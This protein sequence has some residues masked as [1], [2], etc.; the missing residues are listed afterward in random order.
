MDVPLHAAPVAGRFQSR[1]FRPG[2]ASPSG[3]MAYALAVVAM[4]A[5]AALSALLA[6]VERQRPEGALISEAVGRALLLVAVTLG[7]T[8]GH[9]AGFLAAALATAAVLLA[10][11][12]PIFTPDWGNYSGYNSLDLLRDGV[13]V[14]AFFAAA[15]LVGSLA[16]TRRRAE[17]ALRER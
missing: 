15:A 6:Q 7:A 1:P 13:S 4:M 9:R 5:A 11:V 10:P 8:S 2:G 3:F 16:A 12:L 14:G 17:D